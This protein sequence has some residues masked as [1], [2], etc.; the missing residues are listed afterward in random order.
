MNK[1]C[2]GELLPERVKQIIIDSSYELLNEIYDYLRNSRRWLLEIPE[3]VKKEI[4]SDFKH[5]DNAI[6]TLEFIG[7]DS[8]KYWS[9]DVQY[10][11]VFFYSIGK[12][13]DAASQFY[14]AFSSLQ[15]GKKDEYI[16]NITD[17]RDGVSVLLIESLD[18]LNQARQNEK[19]S[20]IKINLP[21]DYCKKFLDDRKQNLNKHHDKYEDALFDEIHEAIKEEV[22]RSLKSKK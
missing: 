6:E 19:M 2:L 13:I 11:W 20:V 3:R 8:S 7:T 5:V 16:S 10:D 14:S 21:H 4:Y 22:L 15:E 17:K 9:W 18:F 12:L 1:E